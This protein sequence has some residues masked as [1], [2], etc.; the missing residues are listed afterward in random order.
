MR[1]ADGIGEDK[2]Q[3]ISLSQRWA[4]CAHYPVETPAQRLILMQV[5]EAC[6]GVLLSSYISKRTLAERTGLSR[7]TIYRHVK[8]LE[9]LGAL[10]A[11]NHAKTTQWFLPEPEQIQAFLAEHKRNREAE[12]AAEKEARRPSIPAEMRPRVET[13]DVSQRNTDVSQRNIDVSQRNTDVS[14]RDPIRDISGNISGMLSGNPDPDFQSILSDA[15]KAPM[16][17]SS[18]APNTYTVRHNPRWSDMSS[19]ERE[20]E[21]DRLFWKSKN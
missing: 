9:Q 4:F 10:T 21:A 19:A 5:G 13:P 1:I 7:T 18:P 11:V 6:D 20:D 3:Q 14:Q 16:L 2:G 17:V 8:R 15:E 12:R